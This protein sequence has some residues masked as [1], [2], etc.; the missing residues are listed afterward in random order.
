MHLPFVRSLADIG[1]KYSEPKGMQSHGGKRTWETARKREGEKWERDRE[2]ENKQR[3]RRKKGINR[4]R[5][6][7][8]G[9]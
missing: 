2:K 5:S 9:E 1:K 4:G 7:T 6:R 8:R 3:E